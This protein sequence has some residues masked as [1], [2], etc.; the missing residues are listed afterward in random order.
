MEESK[1]NIE[2]LDQIKAIMERSTTFVSLSGLSG[3]FSGVIALIGVYILYISFGSLFLSEE[4]FQSLKNEQDLLNK[5]YVVFSSI[6]LL[7]ILFAFVLSF[8]KSKKK[9][10][11]LFNSSSKRFAFN[12]F[13]P[14]ITAIFVVISLI[15][16]Q[17][18]WLIIPMTLIFYGIALINAGKYSRKEILDLGIGCIFSGILSMYFLEFSFILWGIGFG[19]L[20]ILTGIFM[21]Y[22]YDKTK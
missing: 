9:Q 22:K 6:F 18:Y 3:V 5:L 16:H 2:S 20:N 10:Q 15:N 21:Y 19:V 4:I 17:E 1:R 12:L 13:I 11:K 8:L 7:A 14:I